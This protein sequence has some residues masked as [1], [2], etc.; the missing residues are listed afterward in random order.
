MNTVRRMVPVALAVLVACALP[1]AAQVE[2]RL[3]LPQKAR[4]DLEGKESITVAPFLV[5]SQEGQDT[6][7][8]RSVDVEA[9][10]E[11]YLLK[12]LRRET[13]LDIVES[14]SVEYPSY[15]LD[16]VF[17]DAEFWQAVGRRTQ[18]DLLVAGS[19]DFDI[20]DRT[21][22]RTQEF[23]SPVDGR[24]YQRQVLVEQTGFEYDILMVVVDG[25]T[26][27]VLYRDNFKDFQSFQSDEADPLEG[28]FENLYSLEDR[29]L[30][31]FTQKDVEATRVLF[32]R[33]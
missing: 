10:F 32:V 3:Q 30:G 24:V 26:G 23:R 9:E 22:Y 29:I 8:T 11:R 25:A 12:V 28:M 14:G 27:E 13:D 4:L 6:A 20:Q 21:G 31:I 7:R 1:V 5:I 15:D 16:A 17:E 18:A 2:V 19:L 33:N